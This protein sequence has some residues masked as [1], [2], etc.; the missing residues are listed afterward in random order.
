LTIRERQ[1]VGTTS[2][3]KA[4]PVT[5]VTLP[6]GADA[7]FAARRPRIATLDG[8]QSVIAATAGPG[9]V[10]TL[11]IAKTDAAG[12]WNLVAR[13]A[14]QA[15]GAPL[16]VAGVADFSGTGRLDLATI[17]EPD[18]AGVLQ[19]WS[20]AEGAL[21][22]VDEAP[23]F[24]GPTADIDLAAVIP[25]EPGTSASL[26]L[27]AAD[28]GTLAVVALNGRVDEKA[29]VLLPGPA[30]LGVAVLGRGSAA[31]VLVGLADGRLAVVPA[32]PPGTVPP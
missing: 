28:R 4:V 7:V 27:P 32:N 13:S 8:G 10:S 20:Y 12:T 17:R 30:A 3:P 29:R 9:A 1:P 21:T 23:G 11:V 24:A 16:A 31:R 18:G 19:L 2:E 25:G 22:L 26:A 6:P 14:P 15:G 5:S